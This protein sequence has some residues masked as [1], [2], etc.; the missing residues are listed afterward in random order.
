MKPDSPA[1]QDM[2]ADVA[3]EVEAADDAPGPIVDE[4]EPIAFPSSD[5]GK[6]ASV[7]PSANGHVPSPP[8]KD[9]APAPVSFPGVSFPGGGYDDDSQRAASTDTPRA[10]L[11]PGV[12]FEAQ[13]PPSESRGDTPDP[14]A[15]PKRK[16]ISSQNFQRLARRI[17]ITTRRAGSTGAGI[18]MPNI[19]GIPGF[20]RDSSGKSKDD[21]PVTDAP[22][23]TDSPAGSVRGPSEDRPD[24]SAPP[25]R[26]ATLKKKDKKEKRKSTI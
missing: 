6:P 14:E 3:L 24:A 25:S 11:T 22:V 10:A 16:R 12:T 17:S 1:V 9:N 4:S 2:P 20:K 8:P 26:G 23:V 13:S 15:E 19:P 21:A 5:N 18:S 7:A